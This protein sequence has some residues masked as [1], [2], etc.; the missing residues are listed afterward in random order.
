M[1]TAGT[2]LTFLLYCGFMQRGQAAMLTGPHISADYEVV[3]YCRSGPRSAHQGTEPWRSH[4]STGNLHSDTHLPV[5][6]R[7]S[8]PRSGSSEHLSDG[9]R[10]DGEL[11]QRMERLKV[12]ANEQLSVK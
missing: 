4:G 1:T 11:Q 7:S 9:A 6:Q 10:S 12:S 3:L 8:Q 2:I 5:R